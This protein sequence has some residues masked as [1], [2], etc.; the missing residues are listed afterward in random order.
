MDGKLFIAILANK[1]F[2]GGSAEHAEGA[3]LAYLFNDCVLG[4]GGHFVFSSYS[5]R[6]DRRSNAI[7][8]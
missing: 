1:A 5:M 6:R 8:T 7:L 3:M 2:P 4:A